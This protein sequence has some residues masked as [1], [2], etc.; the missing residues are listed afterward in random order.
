MKTVCALFAISAVLCSCTFVT[1][2][3]P[4]VNA[5]SKDTILRQVQAQGPT[6][7]EA[8]KNALFQAVAQAKG[9]KVGSGDYSFGYRSASADINRTGTGKQVAFDAVSVQTAGTLQTTD[10]AGLVKTYEITDEKKL[11]DGNYQVTLKVWVYDHQPLDKSSR[12]R[13]A[14]MPLKTT[15]GSYIFAGL[16][17]PAEQLSDRLAQKLTTAI[18]QTNKFAVLDRQHVAEYLHEQNVLFYSAPIEEQ[19]RI[20]QAIGADYMLVGTINQAEL[21]IVRT[22][23]DAIANVAFAEFDADF[24]FDYRIIV[25]SSRQVKLSDS[26]RLHL[27]TDGV[28]RLVSE[29][30]PSN[31]NYD[32][33][34]D[35]LLAEVAA[36]V[37]DKLSDQLYPPRIASVSPEGVIIDQGGDRFAAGMLL[38]VFKPGQQITDFDTKESLG[39]A[40]VLVATIR[41]DK[42]APTMSYAS[43]VSGDPSKLSQGLVCRAR[44]LPPE[45]LEGAKSRIE[46]TPQGGVKLPFDK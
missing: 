21:R 23:T 25:A 36:R 15:Y 9:V 40:E 10:I 1:A 30:E 41:I 26:V 13:L 6:K 33:L 38:D 43:V 45:E 12:V 46:R 17:V 28:K 44:A 24:A 42:V 18:S 11:P 32:E 4:D 5:Q 16:V 37:V 14:V 22:A 8:I 31:L 19:A 20:G 35:N 2:A 7:D 3:S 39:S 34:V 29:W 27:E